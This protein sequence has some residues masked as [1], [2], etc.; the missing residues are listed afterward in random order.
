MDREF[1][2]RMQDKL[3]ELKAATTPEPIRS[4]GAGALDLGPRNIERDKQNPDILVPPATDFGLIPHL[5]F[6][7]A[8][9]H[10]TLKPGG[11]SREVTSRE[12]AVDDTMAVVDMNLSPGVREMH[13]H[14]QSEFGFVLQ[15]GARVT[16][17]DERGRTFIADCKP[18][19]GWIFPAN[20]PH[21]IQGLREG[22]EF[23]M[24]FDKGSYSEDNT[25][26][27]SELFSHMPKDV[28]SANF[29]CDESEFDVI[30]EKEVYIVDGGDPGTLESQT[31]TSP[32]GVVPNTF[33][34]E[35]INVP[36]IVSD[37][38]SIRILDNANFPACSTT[39]I[40]MVE[41]EPGGMREIHWHTNADELQYYIQG[42]A[43]MTVFKPGPK[44]RTFNFQAGDVGYV[45]VGDFHYVQNI[46]TEKVVYLEVFKSNH[47]SDI[48]LAQWI[49]MTP[50]EVVKSALNLSDEFLNNVKKESCPIV[51]YKGF[52]FPSA[53]KTPQNS[54]YFKDFDFKIKHPP[55]NAAKEH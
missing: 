46:G 28:L 23:L 41:I 30:P 49:A 51:K 16:A 10:M 12:L 42:K 50:K 36:P 15:G 48:S 38:G 11:W 9:A 13:S 54:C 44:S 17:V 21:S 5:K 8:D 25:F 40:A 32:Y 14:L 34:H 7:F 19:E 45:P 37:G 4:D 24:F 52:E 39:S 1:D 43:R 22:C 3:D 47:Y 31:V 29:G 27:I 35:L 18:G 33:K 6:S 26:S 2:K 20:V 55:C 53:N